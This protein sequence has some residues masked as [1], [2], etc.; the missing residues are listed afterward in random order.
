METII[1]T[2]ATG[3]IGR[4]LARAL[5][6]RFPLLLGC[7]NT[8]RAEELA[9]TLPGEVKVGRLDLA[10]S[11]SVRD[12]AASVPTNTHGPLVLLNNAGVMRRRYAADAQGRELSLAVNY[13]NTRLLTELLLRTGRL[14]RVVFT[15]SLTRFCYRP[16]RYRAEASAD[17]FHQLRT[18]GLSKRAI[19]DYAAGLNA[20]GRVEVTCADPGVVDTGMITMQRWYDPLANILFR[21]FIR[22]PRRGAVPAL[23]ALAGAA[24]YIYCARRCHSMPKPPAPYPATSSNIPAL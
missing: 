12:F 7:R 6:P 16:W 9:A 19:T 24:G 17:T 22:S 15:T 14:R 23:R 3:A 5:S 4:E 13:H 18:Y 1:L 2:G 20:S 21:P 10:D 11:E 8:A